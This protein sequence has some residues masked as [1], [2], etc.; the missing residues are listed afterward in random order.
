MGQLKVSDNAATTLAASITSS[1]AVTTITVADASK[2]PVI[3]NAGSG[4][5]WSYVTLYDSANNLEIVKVT[6][7]DTGSNTLTIVRGTAMGISGY[8][9]ADCKA[10]ASTTTGVACRLIAQVVND[11]S[12]AANTAASD[13][14]ASAASA[15]A[16]VAGVK[17]TTAD[18]TPDK[19]NTKIAVTGNLTKA[20][21]N[22]GGNEVLTLGVNVPVSSVFGRTGAVTLGS[23]DVTGALGYTP[24]NFGAS[25]P[26][27][28]GNV[29]AGWI[30]SAL[31][32]T[33]V[34]NAT[35]ATNCPNYLPLAGGTL[36]GNITFS[37]ADLTLQHYDT[38]WGANRYLHSN[39]GSI[40]FL[41]SDGG[42]KAYSENGGNWYVTGNVAAYSDER[43]KTNWRDLQDGFLD[44]LADVKMGIYD[45]VDTEQAMTQ[46]GV[47]A[48]SLQDILPDAVSEGADGY[49]TVAYGNAALAACVALAREVRELR[50]EVKA[51]KGA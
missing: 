33:A 21:T 20:V 38:D 46:V 41:G 23:S 5:D 37:R 11:I 28:S 12:T 22:P 39:G 6:R 15:A 3:N 17:V 45:R 34:T 50:A 35:N 44:Q 18:T 10:W 27:H 13:A 2:F 30:T 25:T 26:W 9:D 36:T 7:R 49:L 31:G 48:Q 47:S 40:G 4:T 42:W 29:T 32:S 14:T 16:A 19:L 8:T 1:P 51:L 43:L 24:Y